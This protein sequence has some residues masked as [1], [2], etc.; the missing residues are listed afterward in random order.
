LQEIAATV[1]LGRNNP[2]VRQDLKTIAAIQDTFFDSL[3]AIFKK[4]QKPE[5]E[6]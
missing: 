2:G 4:P 3:D 6:E 5:E 1:P